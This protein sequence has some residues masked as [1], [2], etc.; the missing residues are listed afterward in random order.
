MP[1]PK[2][3]TPKKPTKA[4]QDLE[5]VLAAAETK[6]GKGIIHRA[7]KTPPVYKL[8][9]RQANMNY[10]TE[11]GLGF[12]RV[13]SLYG[14]SATGKALALDTP[15]PT[16]SGWTT[17]GD[18][19]V[20]DLVF[21][22]QGRATEVL[23]TSP[24]FVDHDCYRVVFDDGSEVIAD[25]DHR[26]L[27]S[28]VLSRQ[29]TERAHARVRVPVSVDGRGKWQEPQPSHSVVTTEDIAASVRTRSGAINHRVDN[30]P[31]VCLPRAAVPVDPYVLGC[32]LGDGSSAAAEFHTVDEQIVDLIRFAGHEITTMKIAADKCP[33]YYIRGLRGHLVSLGVLG[34]KHVPSSYM[35]SSYEQRLALLQGLMDTDGHVEKRSARCEFTT[36]REQLAH[37]VQELICSL[38]MKCR[39][40]KS[41]AKLYGRVIGP[42]WRIG[43]TP[44]EIDVFRLSRKLSRLCNRGRLVEMARSR[45]IVSCE[46]VETV[47]TRCIAVD[48]DSHLFLAGRQMVPTHNTRCAYEQIAQLQG[49]PGT[50]E[51][52]SLPR[53]AYH[54]QQSE[55]TQLNDA[56][57]L[58]HL[59]QAE[60]LTEELEWVRRTFPNGAEAVFYNAEQQFDPRY[61]AAIGVDTKRLKIVETTVI[62]EICDIMENLFKHIPMHV[63]DSTSYASSNLMLKEDVGKSLYAVDARQWK[64][65]L[66]HALSFFDR[67][68][69]QLIMIHQ[70]GT[71]VKSGGGTP[72]STKFMRFASS[73]SIK[74]DRGKFLWMKDGVLV[75]DKPTGADENSLAGRAEADGC[76]VFAKVEKSRTCRPGK[77]A[78]MQWS[79]KKPIGYVDMHDLAASGLYFGMIQKTA[80]GGWFSHVD[81]NGEVQRTGQGLKT[82][83]AH[84]RED[85]SLRSRITCKLLDF[86]DD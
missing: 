58:L 5:K 27:T 75:E 11:G 7:D 4:E 34:N 85:E 51:V 64:T 44:G 65:S 42:K 23:Q 37:D 30:H 54:T 25:A 50:L 17:M 48:S 74:F 41:D 9:F 22:D 67:E 21:D 31:G 39:V 55:N 79:Y 45:A 29:A 15:I 46:E 66:K 6:Y 57:R 53:I 16:P 70:M 56:H 38:G 26:W 52:Y 8:P 71:N 35:R 61:A 19:E 24:V 69:N 18:I 28:T 33:R 60:W 1:A 63:V 47:P 49:L 13:A 59:A 83:Y 20:G 76:E 82:V 36:T 78:G 86:T 3:A 40:T 43:F 2:K 32:W 10:A 84:L 72:N 73:C 14:E 81:E 62:E 77:I 12:G 80:A 68:H